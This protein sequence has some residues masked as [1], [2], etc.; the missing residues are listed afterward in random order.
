MSPFT[1]GER[2]HKSR[3]KPTW[4][5]WE[6]MHLLVFVL[7]VG[8]C[9]LAST[10]SHQLPETTDATAQPMFLT[11]TAKLH[12]ANIARFLPSV[13]S[14]SLRDVVDLGNLHRFVRRQ[15]LSWSV[16]LLASLLCYCETLDGYSQ[17]RSKLSTVPIP[18][19]STELGEPMQSSIQK[20]RRISTAKIRLVVAS[21][22]AENLTPGPQP[23]T[24]TGETPSG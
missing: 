6:C 12:Q 15:R 4:V 18:K 8:S 13:K 10:K 14:L 21:P 11:G 24:Q 1:T 23:H 7:D 20:Q 19:V 2:S 9:C 3:S 16:L 17:D 22:P 5:V